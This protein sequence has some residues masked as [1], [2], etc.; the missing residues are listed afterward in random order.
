MWQWEDS[1]C[2]R[3]GT[4]WV[5]WPW[6]S[7]FMAWWSG[8]WQ[9]V[10]SASLWSPQGQLPGSSGCPW[11][12]CLCWTGWCWRWTEAGLRWSTLEGSVKLSCDLAS[13]D[14]VQNSPLM[15]FGTS[16]GMVQVSPVHHTGHLVVTQSWVRV[17]EGWLLTG[18]LQHTN[19]IPATVREGWWVLWGTYITIKKM[20]RI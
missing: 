18:L 16:H 12:W 17:R 2:R 8:V 3:N 6:A 5:T 20:N 13:D 4:A 19:G 15:P 7:L 14:S 10:W 1:T 11:H 9:G